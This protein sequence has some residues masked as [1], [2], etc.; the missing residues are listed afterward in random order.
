MPE[1]E[2]SGWPPKMIGKRCL[3]NENMS[4]NYSAQEKKGKAMRE[5]PV[6]RH[7]GYDR[8]NSETLNMRKKGYLRSY[9]G[10]PDHTDDWLD[11]SRLW[12]NM[13]P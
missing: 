9:L 4:G 1:V 5:S 3:L 13:A 12:R 7:L 6:G 10:D 2:S 8:E 11:G